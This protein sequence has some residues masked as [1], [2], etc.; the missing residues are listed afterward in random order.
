SDLYI[1]LGNPTPTLGRETQ[2]VYGTIG[3]AM[4][5]HL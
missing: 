1:G 4:F 3:D 5:N 2:T